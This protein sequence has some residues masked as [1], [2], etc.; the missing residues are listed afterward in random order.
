M[1]NLENEINNKQNIINYHNKNILKHNDIYIDIYHERFYLTKPD[2]NNITYNGG[3]LLDENSLGKTLCFISLSLQEPKSSLSQDMNYKQKHIEYTYDAK[4]KTHI[5]THA[6]LIICPNYLCNHWQTEIKK[7]TDNDVNIIIIST[8]FQ[9][10]K[11]TYQDIL[12]ANFVILSVNFLENPIYKNNIKSYQGNVQT[13]KIIFSNINYELLNNTTI[14]NII[15]KTNIILHL[16]LWYRIVIDQLQDCYKRIDLIELFAAKYKWCITTKQYLK[17]NVN[18]IINIIC[19]K[20]KNKI[21]D[22]DITQNILSIFSNKLCRYNTHQSIKKEF[23]LTQKKD[24]IIWLKFTSSE[25][26]IY[27]YY[28][29]LYHKDTLLQF[30]LHP[31][32]GNQTKNFIKNC[33]TIH[34]IKKSLVEMNSKI[35]TKSTN[36]FNLIKKD[37]DKLTKNKGELEDIEDISEIKINIDNKISILNDNYNE[38]DKSIDF[39]KKNINY[40]QNITIND[41]NICPICLCDIDKIAITY[42]GHI[43]C[44]DCMGIIENDKINKCPICRCN[45]EENSILY[46]VDDNIDIE[47]NGTKLTYL[48]SYVKNKP[49]E[50][51]IILTR[52][53]EMGQKMYN[54]F[55]NNNIKAN[56]YKGNIIQKNKVIT[57]FYNDT[58]ILILYD[59][60][61]LSIID[62]LKIKHLILLDPEYKC[63]DNIINWYNGINKNDNISL[64]RFLIS[65]TLEEIIYKKNNALKMQ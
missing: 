9:Y 59:E 35:I 36:H 40:L 62:P 53:D 6:T 30:C 29:N 14:K 11:V 60:N 56:I 27:N 58:D 63:E 8:K 46:L 25:L 2:Y 45:I 5:K 7:H 57:D 3:I 18:N 54:M 50:K 38:L 24:K 21:E 26:F 43:F 49:N 42:C 52:W 17:S 33:K 1:I 64:V 13:L 32:I 44:H 65:D 47:K 28:K 61:N 10:E 20:D 41:N 16:F 19:H 51:I 37:I 15:N 34:D 39:H 48:N 22:S 23:K 55:Q 12:D 4:S 31:H